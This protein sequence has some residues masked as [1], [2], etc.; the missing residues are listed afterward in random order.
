MFL[1]PLNLIKSDTHST[2]SQSSTGPSAGSQ[3]MYQGSPGRGSE[4][5][6]QW[7]VKAEDPKWVQQWVRSNQWETRLSPGKRLPWSKWPW[8]ERT[9]QGNRTWG[10][11][12]DPRSAVCALILCPTK[13]QGCGC[14][15]AVCLGQSWLDEFVNSV[16][17]SKEKLEKQGRC[18]KHLTY[19]PAQMQ[20][21]LIWSGDKSSPESSTDPQKAVV[22]STCIVLRRQVPCRTEKGFQTETC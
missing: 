18:R 5:I 1:F 8:K 17:K 20:W 21:H 22:G 12:T 7:K 14:R 19:N 16:V 10:R 11:L 3:D 15:P 13:W 9:R 4:G 6:P 2:N